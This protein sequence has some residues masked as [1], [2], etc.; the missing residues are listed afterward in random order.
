MWYTRWTNRKCRMFVLKHPKTHL[1]ATRLLY[2]PRILR[3]HLVRLLEISNSCQKCS[4]MTRIG[5]RLLPQISRKRQ[6]AA[7]D[8]LCLQ[9][10]KNMPR[11]Y[12]HTYAKILRLLCSLEIYPSDS[13]RLLFK[14]SRAE[15]FGY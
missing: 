3:R 9:N 15:D 12:A 10:A 5:T 14:R 8:V 1:K 7:R 13:V 4:Q 2:E 6:K 11:C